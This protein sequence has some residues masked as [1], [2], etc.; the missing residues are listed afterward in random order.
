MNFN[1]CFISYVQFPLF[2]GRFHN[3]HSTYRVI[4]NYVSNTK[5]YIKIKKTVVKTCENDFSNTKSYNKTV[6]VI[7][8]SSPVD[9]RIYLPSK[10]IF[11]FLGR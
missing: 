4:F 2:E 1:N 6:T 10:V 7:L 8:T 3:F 11:T 9:I 5:C